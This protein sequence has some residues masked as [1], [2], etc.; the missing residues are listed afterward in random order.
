MLRISVKSLN[1]YDYYLPRFT[2]IRVGLIGREIL[3]LS[4]KVQVVRDSKVAY[5]KQECKKRKKI[6]M[7]SYVVFM[8]YSQGVVML[9]VAL[10]QHTSF[11]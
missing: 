11:V 1:W 10:L 5:R 6:K 8:F 3:V 9:L 7:L 2:E 4:R